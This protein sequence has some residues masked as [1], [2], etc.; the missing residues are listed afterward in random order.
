[1][2]P[3][4]RDIRFQLDPARVCDWHPDDRKITHFY[5]A[6]SIFFPEG[7]RFF[8]HSVRHYRDR[9]ADPELQAAVTAF[10]GQE[11]MHG[12]EHSDYNRALVEAGLPVQQLEGIVI[13]L[14]E[15]L[16]RRL[17]PQL[18]LS[19][20]IA[21][22]H[23]TAIMAD[24]LLRNPHFIEGADPRYTALWRWH[25]L[26]E[27]EHKAVAF[28]V[29]DSVFGRGVRAYVVRAIGLLGASLVF[30][31]LVFAF[32]LRLIA[33]DRKTPRLRGWGRMLAFLYGPRRGLFPKLLRPWLDYF[34][35]SFHPWDHDNRALLREVDAVVAAVD[36]RLPAAA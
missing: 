35:P 22:E 9:I 20:T 5:N 19:A 21:L 11:A 15:R 12:R 13:R 32:H 1:M 8:I 28:D 23:L 6:L 27:T 31:P 2:Q 17:P 14:L 36:G 33:A 3:I 29:Y 24:A 18:Q 26:E 7:E 30:W 34:R 10:I 16:K 4:R 25:A